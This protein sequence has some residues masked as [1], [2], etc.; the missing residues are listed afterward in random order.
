MLS[1]KALLGNTVY[2]LKVCL[3]IDGVVLA[4]FYDKSSQKEVF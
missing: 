1:Y 3:D 4:N 2:E